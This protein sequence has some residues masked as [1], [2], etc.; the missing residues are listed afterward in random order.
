M[1]RLITTTAVLAISALS[2]VHAADVA[3]PATGVDVS[4]YVNALV[5]DLGSVTGIAIGAGFAIFAL[6]MGFKYVRRAIK[7]A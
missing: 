2:T 5:Q 3:L 4:A 1:R 7:G 6:W